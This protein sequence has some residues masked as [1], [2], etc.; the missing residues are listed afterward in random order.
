[1]YA[2]NYKPLLGKFFFKFSLIPAGYA[3]VSFLLD[4]YII[5]PN[6]I[7]FFKNASVCLPSDSLN[8]VK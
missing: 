3:N 1:M 6:T 8:V 5:I 2:C 7:E 4:P